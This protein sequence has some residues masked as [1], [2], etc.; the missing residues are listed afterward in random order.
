MV[1]S[2][3]VDNTRYVEVTCNIY[4]DICYHHDHT[5]TCRQSICLNFHLHEVQ[6]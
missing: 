1:K 3:H 5:C 2:N 6:Y 4:S